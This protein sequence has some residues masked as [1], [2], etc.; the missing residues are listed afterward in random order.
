MVFFK[1]QV[2]VPFAKRAEAV[3]LFNTFIGPV[4]V[5]PGLIGAGF[6]DEVEGDEMV[7]ME[8][9]RSQ[10]DMERHLCSEE[11]KNVL[12][13]MDFAEEQPEIHFHTVSSTRGL[14]WLKQLR[15]SATR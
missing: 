8:E 9:W 2:K 15:L 12:A 3:E 1:L 14:E 10:K 11:F 4:L 13:V 5:M 7:L 6:Y